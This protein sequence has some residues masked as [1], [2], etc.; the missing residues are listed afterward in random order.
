MPLDKQEKIVIAAAAAVGLVYFGVLNPL[1]KAL[2]LKDSAETEQLNKEAETPL[3][4]WSAT[5]WQNTP[6]AVLI[7]QVDT[8]AYCKT[9]YDSFGAF[10]DCEECAIAVFK[11]LKYKTQV[12]WLAYQFAEIYGQDLLSFLRGGNWPQDRLSDTTVSE[13]TAYLNK[14][15]LK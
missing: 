8:N 3:S 1:L 7:R 12:S 13:L 15:P 5:L 2:G 11:G 6:G 4:V 14:L 9:I 10:N